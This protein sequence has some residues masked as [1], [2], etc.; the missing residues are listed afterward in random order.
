MFY[1]YKL[2]MK[3]VI[4]LFKTDIINEFDEHFKIILRKL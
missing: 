1:K 4:N 3:I 2:H